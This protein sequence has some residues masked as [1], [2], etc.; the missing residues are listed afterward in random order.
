M[1]V[2]ISRPP[3]LEVS[4]NKSTTHSQPTFTT[5]FPLHHKFYIVK[6]FGMITKA[7]LE[8]LILVRLGFWGSQHDDHGCCEKKKTK[9]EQ[10][11]GVCT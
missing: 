7:F 11:K 10:G 3:A 5:K 8:E 1:Y 2:V 9:K 4:S 6:M